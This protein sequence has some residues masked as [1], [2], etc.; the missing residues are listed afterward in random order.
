MKG[1]VGLI[2]SR[3]YVETPFTGDKGSFLLS[4]RSSYSN[5]L[6]H[7]IP[8]VDLMNSS[9]NFFDINS[10]FTYNLNP[11]NRLNLFAY[12]SFD[13]FGFSKDTKYQYDNFLVSARW[14]HTFT[15]DLFFDLMAGASN[16]N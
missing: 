1:G 10:M 7:R 11:L 14:K 3:V 16:Y 5:W 2:D 4:A 12:Y 6:L 13:K 15:S 9:A 8:D